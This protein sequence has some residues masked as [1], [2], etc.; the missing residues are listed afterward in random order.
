MAPSP[1]EP[2]SRPSCC[3][4]VRWRPHHLDLSRVVTSCTAP[5]LP[6][7]SMKSGGGFTIV[8]PGM[9]EDS[10]Q[11]LVEG[12]RS[13]QCRNGGLNGGN[14]L[15]SSLVYVPIADSLTPT[16]WHCHPRQGPAMLWGSCDLQLQSPA[17]A[18]ASGLW[19]G[20]PASGFHSSEGPGLAGAGSVPVE[21][22]ARNHSLFWRNKRKII[23]DKRGARTG[24]GEDSGPGPGP[25][26]EVGRGGAGGVRCANA[27]EIARILWL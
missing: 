19:P 9:A 26:G 6:S 22:S 7:A 8:E 20:A 13:G 12:S 17:S 1:V 2:S 25:R 10:R 16:P 21:Q 27:G 5:W 23:G 24:R 4:L 14:I 3:P 18:V 11:G 15:L